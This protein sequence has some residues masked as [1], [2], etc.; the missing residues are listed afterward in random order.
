MESVRGLVRRFPVLTFFTL[1]FGLS[2]IAW[3]PYVLGN[4]GLGWEPEFQLPTGL[5][6]QLV[7]MLPGAYLGP[8][9]AAFIVTALTEGRAGLRQWA[10]R[11]LRWRVGWF[12]YVTILIAVPATILL[13][14]LTLPGAVDG[15][16][17]PSLQVLALF[18]PLLVLQFVTTAAAEEPGWRDFALPRLQDRFGPVIGTT[19]LG[20]LW[21]CW[22]LPLFCTEWGGWPDVSWI[23]PVLFVASCVP[24]SLVMT[25]LFNRTG[26]SLPIVMVFHAAIN[27][28]Y[29]ILWPTVFTKLNEFRDTLAVNLIAA[30][31]ASVV[32]IIVTRGRLGLRA[33][34]EPADAEPPTRPLDNAFVA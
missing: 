4:T 8:L 21:G 28:T 30:L 10:K 27:T 6:G 7:G 3:T 23:E 2:W 33:E 24:L 32:L 16:A 25:W 15:L 12:W 26:Q 18:L 34:R 31:A 20:V 9:S 14:T 17:A 1:A 5:A 22:H 11:L 19:I 13:V 29:S